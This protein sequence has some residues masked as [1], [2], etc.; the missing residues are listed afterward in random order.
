MTAHGTSGAGRTVIS[1]ERAPA[2]IG[3]YSQAIRAG[4]FLFTAGQIPLDPATMKLVEGDITVQTERVI[5]NL[6]AV[7]EA[8]G[9]SFALVV[10]TTCFLANLD[11]FP[12]FNAVYSRAFPESPPARSTVQVARLPAGALVEV[13]CVALVDGAE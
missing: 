11:D 13:E 5:D 1:T 2:A 6:R 3:P 7:L 10:K 12:A 9:T 8:A 4:G